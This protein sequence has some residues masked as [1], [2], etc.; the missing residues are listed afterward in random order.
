M[1]VI[2][3]IPKGY[4]E[5][6]EG[7]EHVLMLKGTGADGADTLLALGKPLMTLDSEERLTADQLVNAVNNDPRSA[8]LRARVAEAM[9]MEAERG[10]V[11]EEPEPEDPAFWDLVEKE[12]PDHTTFDFGNYCP[13]A[14]VTMHREQV[15]KMIGDLVDAYLEPHGP[16]EMVL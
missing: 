15:P 10:I 2:V 4:E 8:E 16:V 6:F 9:E 7:G 11:Y 14:V 5:A 12:F 3:D 13:D 1:R